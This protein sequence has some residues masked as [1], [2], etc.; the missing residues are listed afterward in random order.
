MAKKRLTPSEKLEAQMKPVPERSTWLRTCGISLYQPVVPT[1]MLAPARRVASML[2]MTASGVVKSMTASMPASRCRLSAEP[3]R[4]SWT[5]MISQVWPRDSATS[6]TT[7]PVFPAPNRT[8]FIEISLRG[9]KTAGFK[10]QEKQDQLQLP[11]SSK[12]GL[13]GPPRSL[14]AEKLQTSLPAQTLLGSF[15]FAALSVRMTAK[16]LQQTE[17]PNCGRCGALAATDF[18]PTI[19]VQIALCLEQLGV[20]QCGPGGP[21]NRI[22]REHGELPVEE[23][24][25]PQASAGDGHTVAAVQVQPR[26]GPVGALVVVDHLGWGEGP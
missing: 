3:L 10:F 26:L 14:P 2:V 9:A 22:V 16:L 6:A 1:T 23:R 20:E 11:H 17:I 24:A 5:S 7:A 8:N 21:A 18:H 25:R 4:F 19:S 12:S 13:S 15:R